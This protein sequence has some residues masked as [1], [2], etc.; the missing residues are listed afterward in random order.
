MPFLSI[1]VGVLIT[2]FTWSFASSNL[3]CKKKFEIFKSTKLKW[4]GANVMSMFIAA[5]LVSLGINGRDSVTSCGTRT[6]YV[7]IKD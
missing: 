7:E 4:K 6:K 3:F 1:V 5:S 2:A